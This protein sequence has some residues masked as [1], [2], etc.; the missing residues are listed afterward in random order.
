MEG[1]RYL[2][3]GHSII[4][5]VLCL[6]THGDRGRSAEVYD[7]RC[8]TVSGTPNISR[9]RS[10]PRRRC[11]CRWN[12]R[13]NFIMATKK[14][15]NHKKAAPRKLHAKFR[16]HQSVCKVELG[17]EFIKEMDGRKGRK[18]AL[19]SFGYCLF[20]ITDSARHSIE[21]AV[22]GATVRRWGIRGRIARQGR[23]PYAKYVAF[24]GKIKFLWTFREKSVLYRLR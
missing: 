5:D 22:I 17:G 2:D 20:A 1:N 12:N 21:D 10:R 16:P 13:R 3:D 18:D 9:R 6:R 23:K 4:P 19:R 7:V 24:S 14:P 15:T 11:G 8:A